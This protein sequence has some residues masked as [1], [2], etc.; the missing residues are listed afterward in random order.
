MS[1]IISEMDGVGGVWLWFGAPIMHIM[2]G[3]GL[4]RHCMLGGDMVWEKPFQCRWVW[5]FVVMGSYIYFS[6][7]S[8]EIY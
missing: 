4:A 2:L 8:L 7:Q 6:V 1:C 5:W 3:Q